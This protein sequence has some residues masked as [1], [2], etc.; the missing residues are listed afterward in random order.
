L[1]GAR[2]ERPEEHANGEQARHRLGEPSTHDS[3]CRKRGLNGSR[4]SSR[5]PRPPDPARCSLMPPLG[6]ASP[7]EW[8]NIAPSDRA[9]PR[10]NTARPPRP[11]NCCSVA[12]CR[13][14]S[15]SIFP[16]DLSD[17]NETASATSPGQVPKRTPPTPEAPADRREALDCRQHMPRPR[18]QC[19]GML[20]QHLLRPHHH[21]RSNLPTPLQCLP[22]P[23]IAEFHRP[24]LGCR[25]DRQ[26]RA[27][28]A[29]APART[30]RAIG[31]LPAEPA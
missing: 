4:I 12:A 21:R 26:A 11:G 15:R 6:A 31:P 25:R 9:E 23:A 27:R 30:P 8:S 17:P 7:D 20:R 10:R 14:S 28:T 24:R 18:P 1:R 2:H 29:N 19:V 22:E 16:P 3:S 5:G 13:H